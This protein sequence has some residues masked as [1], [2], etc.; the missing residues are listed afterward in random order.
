MNPVSIR[1]IPHSS[2]ARVLTLKRDFLIGLGTVLLAGLYLAL[3]PYQVQSDSDG[4]DF[5]SGRTL[6]F[7]VGGLLLIT[8]TA[9]TIT[10]LRTMNRTSPHEQ[11]PSPE[12]T[13]HRYKRV[14]I[15]T[16][17]AVLYI[18]GL[19]YIG[20]IVSTI[21]ALAAAMVFSGERRKRLVV[22][23]S[24]LTSVLLYYFFHKLMQ[25]PLPDTLLF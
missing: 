24:I 12:P 23:I 21:L 11:A 7:M 17:L 18:L 4:Y 10:S 22:I 9:L 25:V 19:T 13:R 2:T 1:F 8:G 15:L 20:Y 16:A 3:I 5:V 6:P 14:A